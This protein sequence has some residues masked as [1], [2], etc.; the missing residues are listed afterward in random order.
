MIGGFAP[1]Q[2]NLVQSFKQGAID[3]SSSNRRI[4]DLGDVTTLAIKSLR[5][6]LRNRGLTVRVDEGTVVRIILPRVA[7]VG[8]TE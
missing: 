6:G 5:T 3:Q 1:T 4:F 7:P 8:S 2:P